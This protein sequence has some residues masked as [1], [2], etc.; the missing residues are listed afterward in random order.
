MKVCLKKL[1]GFINTWVQLKCLL[2]LK[3]AYFIPHA[4]VLVLIFLIFVALT[5]VRSSECSRYRGEFWSERQWNC[6]FSGQEQPAHC[7]CSYHHHQWHSWIRR[8]ANIR[9]LHYWTQQRCCGNNSLRTHRRNNCGWWRYI[10]PSK[11]TKIERNCMFSLL[12]R[13]NSCNLRH[14]Y[15]TFLIS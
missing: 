10:W 8:H 3:L 5:I 11:F 12:K 1:D 4:Y 13:C 2:P 14:A 7:R 9:S 6:C 15:S